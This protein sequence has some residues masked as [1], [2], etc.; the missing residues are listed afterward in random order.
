[1]RS[2]CVNQNIKFEEFSLPEVLMLVC[3]ETEIADVWYVARPEVP[4]FGI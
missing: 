1:M 4:M 2:K 3:S